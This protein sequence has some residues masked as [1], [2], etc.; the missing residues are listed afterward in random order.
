MTLSELA[1]YLKV[2]EKTVMRMINRKEI[3]A[4]KIGSQWRF[5]R[6]MVDDWVLSNMQVLPRNDLA[7]LMEDNH[8]LVPLS[9][10][11]DAESII[12]NLKPGTKQEVLAQLIRPLEATDQ[13][14]DS[15]A[16]LDILLAREEMM[17][18]AIGPI[19]FPHARNPQEN[20]AAEPQVIVGICRDGTEFGSLDGSPTYL[21]MLPFTDSEIIHLKLMAKMAVLFKEEKNVRRVL[22]AKSSEHVVGVLISLEQQHRSEQD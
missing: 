3:P 18:T 8:D 5:S 1:E 10:L 6:S 4:I 19:A 12:M 14:R 20:E 2:A 17:T 22:E 16:Y 15:A 13:I 21:F 9:R 7:K 11:V